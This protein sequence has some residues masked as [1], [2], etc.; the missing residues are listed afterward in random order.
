LK[1]GAERMLDLEQ[2]YATVAGYKLIIESKSD[3]IPYFMNKK[4]M[5]KAIA[6]A[7]DLK[8]QGLIPEMYFRIKEGRL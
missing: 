7:N 3:Y 6:Y 5:S 8:R 2:M 4:A 1:K